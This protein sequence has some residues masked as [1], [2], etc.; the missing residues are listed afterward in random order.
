[1]KYN[2][3]IHH[4]RSIRLKGYDY[5]QPGYYFVTICT[6]KGKCILGEVEKDVV[7]LSALGEIVES[8]WNEIP[9][10]FSNV[11]L[12]AYIIMPNHVH[13]ILEIKP[14]V[15]SVGAEHVQP[16]QNSKDKIP[17]Y[18]HVIPGSLGSIV[19]QF[20]AAVTREW[21]KNPAC[22][23][24]EI[25]QRN[26]YEH[27]IRSDISHFFIAQYIEINP[28]I[29]AFDRDNPTTNGCSLD[30]LSEILERKFN[31][32][33]ERL[34]SIIEHETSYRKWLEEEDQ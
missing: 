8:C 26:Y 24:A 22:A 20:K 11:R 31:I 29:W 19:R 28:L 4:R 32:T 10:H 23:K 21:R 7:R 25:W 33:G 2:P 5:S 17:K 6:E 16:L 14:N 27:I 18:Q 12:D 30:E 3:H 1:M 34:L 13:G 9:K 15:N